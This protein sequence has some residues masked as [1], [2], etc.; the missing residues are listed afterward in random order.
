[1]SDVPLTG[2]K[3][4]RDIGGIS[5]DSGAVVQP[6]RLLRTARL[7]RPTD[8]DLAWLASIGLRTVVDLRQ[9]FE[10]VAWPDQLGDL[11]VERVNVAPSLDSEG[12][13]TFFELYLAWLDESG[14]AFADAVHAL[15]KP[16]ALPALVHC[17]AGKDRTGVLVALVLDVLGVGEKAIVADYLISNERLTTDPGDITF[18]H[19]ISEDLISGSL[20]HVR[21][22]YGSAEGYLLAHGVSDE[23]IAAL[24][25]A[26]LG[27]G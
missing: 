26:L 21:A 25:E 1:M 27:E 3:N 23:E 9:H 15:A 2:V 20:A 13:G 17:T 5:T 11:P 16:G 12:A 18:Q 8:A 4:A 19:P 6:L 24:R 22:R 10:I 14:H 7:N